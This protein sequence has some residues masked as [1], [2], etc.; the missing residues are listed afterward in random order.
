MKGTR[1]CLK[2]QQ[3]LKE[4]D[5]AYAL[6]VIFRRAGLLG[7]TFAAIFQAL[8]MSGWTPEWSAISC[9]HPRHPL[10]SWT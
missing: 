2:K 1:V 7:W 5:R 9:R 10:G 8:C 3:E 4:T 6:G